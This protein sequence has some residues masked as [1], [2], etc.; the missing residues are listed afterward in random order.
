M[1][2]GT[3][4]L[5]A[6]EISLA[7]IISSAARGLPFKPVR[8]EFFP[9]FTTPPSTKSISSQW[10]RHFKLKPLAYSMPRRIMREFITDL[11]SSESATAPACA[12]LPISARLS[13][14]SPLVIAPIG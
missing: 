9:S 12:I 3:S 6:S 11:P 10:Q 2:T 13:P 14:F 7:I 4:K 1:W 8:V 5:S